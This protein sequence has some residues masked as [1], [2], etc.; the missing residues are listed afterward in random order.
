MASVASQL[1]ERVPVLP[2]LLDY[3]LLPATSS[4]TSSTCK[5]TPELLPQDQAIDGEIYVCV[6]EDLVYARFFADFGPLNLGQTMRFGQIVDEKLRSGALVVLYSSDHPHKRAN[7]MTLLALYL[8]I[9]HKHTPEDAVRVFQ[10]L[11]PP[12]G[13]RDAACGLCTFF[14]TVL[15]CAR[16]VHKVLS[17]IAP[18][19]EWWSTV[20][21][22]C[23]AGAAQSI[24]CSIWDAA[25]FSLTAYEHLDQLPNGDI[26]WIVPGKLLAF[27]GPQR[28]RVTLDDGRTTLLAHEYARV[29]HQ[30]GVSCVV[31]FNEPSSY[32][33][34][35]FLHA[36]IR[37]VRAL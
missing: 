4:N 26:N 2:G 14:I 33:R 1:C 5:R 8:V 15:D 25:S 23:T 36:G 31:R 37:H 28:E 16:A 21:N 17:S 24:E 35:A 30:L 22:G 18:S 27:S 29:F 20:S 10:S 9:Q 3:A 6:D 11:R 13:F 12:F 19:V 34:K 32:D 7:A